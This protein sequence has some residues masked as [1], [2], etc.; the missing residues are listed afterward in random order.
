MFDHSVLIEES[1]RNTKMRKIYRY[2][3][4]VT[5]VGELEQK[6][7]KVLPALLL[8]RTYLIWDCQLRNDGALAVYCSHDS[9]Q[10][11]WRIRTS[12]LNLR[13]HI[14]EERVPACVYEVNYLWKKAGTS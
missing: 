9:N 3:M 4:Y 11:Q 1:E 10:N 2:V 5:F 13:C 14:K 6:S 12:S 7:R 8:D